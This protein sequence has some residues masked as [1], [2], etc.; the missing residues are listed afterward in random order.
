[1]T[2]LPSS[3]LFP[4]HSNLHVTTIISVKYL[5]KASCSA[6]N[7]AQVTVHDGNLNTRG[8]GA[9][10]WFCSGVTCVTHCETLTYQFVQEKKNIE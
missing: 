5:R 2:N 3:S 8:G 10:L 6:Q 4:L 7:G 9:Q 1:M